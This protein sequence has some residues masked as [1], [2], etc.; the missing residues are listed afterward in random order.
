MRVELTAARLNQR[1]DQAGTSFQE[2]ASAASSAARNAAAAA[3]D[4]AAEGSRQCR[5]CGRRELRQW[6]SGCEC[7]KTSMENAFDPE[8]T[9]AMALLAV[10]IATRILLPGDVLPRFTKRVV[11]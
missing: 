2:T 8:T 4:A 7:Y 5:G 9:R 1:A 10:N 3:C 11:P 6:V